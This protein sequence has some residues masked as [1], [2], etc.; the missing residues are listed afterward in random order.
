MHRF[1]S[2]SKY[3][4]GVNLYDFPLQV[5]REYE[6]QPIEAAQQTGNFGAANVVMISER[7]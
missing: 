5:L 1:H 6:P 2:T 3:R 7:E 4:R